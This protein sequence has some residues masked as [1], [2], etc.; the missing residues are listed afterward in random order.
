MAYLLFNG[1][2]DKDITIFPLNFKIKISGAAGTAGK[3]H[4][5]DLI[6]SDVDRWFMN[7]HETSLQRIQVPAV[8]LVRTCYGLMTLGA[9]RE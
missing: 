6:E 4:A 5:R 2:E 3:V 7:V 1:A 8:G 9:E